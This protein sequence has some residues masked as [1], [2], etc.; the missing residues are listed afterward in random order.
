MASLGHWYPS[1]CGLLP[2]IASILFDINHIFAFKSWVDQ[3]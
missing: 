3:S 1:F 2:N